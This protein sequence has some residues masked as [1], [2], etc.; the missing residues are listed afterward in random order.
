MKKFISFLLVVL[1]VSFLSSCGKEKDEPSGSSLAGT[2]WAN[3]LYD[4]K[5]L[6]FEF[7]TSSVSAFISDSY[8]NHLYSRGGGSYKFDGRNVTFTN[9]VL[10]SATHENYTH[11]EVAGSSMKAYYWYEMGGSKYDGSAVFHKQ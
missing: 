9:F 6:V 10:T 2:S 8:G 7:S 5:Y 4:D 11:A 3:H 1:A